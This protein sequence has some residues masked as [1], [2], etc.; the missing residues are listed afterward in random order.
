MYT[1]NYSEYNY[2]YTYNYILYYNIYFMLL[3]HI[4]IGK[5]LR[6]IICIHIIIRENLPA[7]LLYIICN[8]HTLI[9]MGNETDSFMFNI[10]CIMDQFIKK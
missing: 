1:Y 3:L 7:C 6:I 10:P 5:I 8:K 9:I 2:I 4:I